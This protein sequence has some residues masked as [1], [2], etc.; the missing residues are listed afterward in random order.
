QRLY[1]CPSNVVYGHSQLLE[2]PPPLVL[3]L[4]LEILNY[5]A[6]NHSAV[7]NTLFYFEPSLLPES[8]QKYAVNKK[9]KG[10]EKVGE[11][12]VPPNSVQEY[13]EGGT[14]LILLLK[15][16]NRPL[17]RRSI[18]HVE[19]V[20][21]LLQVVVYTAASRLESPSLPEQVLDDS[22]N[23]P[24]KASDEVERDV[25]LVETETNKQNKV[26]NG[27]PSISDRSTGHNI[28]DVFTQQPKSDL[29]YLSRLLGYEG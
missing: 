8:F 24:S 7:A 10:K 12:G 28:H 20:M 13:K 4:V 5:L 21:G 19:Q 17:F 14:P 6:T 1:G 15:L 29:R 3:R 26:E 9:G 22:Q 2:G 18:A 27:E 16:L 25:A 23:L 11:A